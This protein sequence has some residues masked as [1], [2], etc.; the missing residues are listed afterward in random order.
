MKTPSHFILL[1]FSLALFLSNRQR[2]VCN[3]GTL[4]FLQRLDDDYKRHEVR[5]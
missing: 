4:K 5:N 3:D 2:R 1:A